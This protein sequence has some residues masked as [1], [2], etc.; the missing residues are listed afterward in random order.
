MLEKDKIM[1]DFQMKSGG[2]ILRAF[3]PGAIA[4]FATAG[5]LAALWMF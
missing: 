3:T 4:G 5:C 2:N 1:K